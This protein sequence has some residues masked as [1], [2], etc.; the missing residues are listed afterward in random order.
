[1]IQLLG[2]VLLLSGAVGFGLKG[3]A[4]LRGR[5]R[6][7]AAMVSSLELL[8]SEICDRLTPM[9]ELLE[10]L[11]QEATYPAS[12][13]YGGVR[14]RMKDLGE[15]SFPEI[16][17]KAVS[18]TPSLTLDAQ[19]KL[20]LSELGVSLGKYD[21]AE[22]A[23]AIGSARRRLETLAAQA[24]AERDRDSKLHA[25]LGVAAGIFAIVLLI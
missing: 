8:Q 4:R 6:T 23:G 13:F 2:A 3:V 7:L 18:E 17:R 22:Q 1:M 21:A 10:L 19:D 5:A 12:A 15:E 24:A 20:I 25:A 16:W 14:R 11:E 9:P